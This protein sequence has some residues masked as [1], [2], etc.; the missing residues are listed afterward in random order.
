MGEILLSRYDMFCNLK[1]YRKVL[2]H[3]TTNLNAEE[4][5]KRYDSRVGSR[6]TAMFNLI[7]FNKNS[8]NKRIQQEIG[9][10]KPHS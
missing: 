4:L 5:K 10:K 8:I 3:I 9:L 1:H 2:T 6:L 7:S